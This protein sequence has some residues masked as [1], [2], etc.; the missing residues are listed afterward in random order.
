VLDAWALVA[1][2]D[3][4]E[5]AAVEVETAL[6][7][8]SAAAC[9]IN[10]GEVLYRQIRAVGRSSARE[11]I[12]A[13]RHDIEVIDADWDLVAAA[14]EIKA[15]GGLSYAD[16]FCIATAVRLEAPLWTGD[17]EIIDQAAEL[18]CAVR[19]LRAADN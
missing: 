5:P 7:E 1:F 9:S 16:A 6:R 11:G 15:R 18:P 3:D 2:L 4:Q 12:A 19:D 8:E 14:A 10:V 17:P 13:L